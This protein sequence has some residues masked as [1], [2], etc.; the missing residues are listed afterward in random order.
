MAIADRCDECDD[1]LHYPSLHA[2]APEG[3]TEKRDTL[4][5]VVTQERRGPS[6]AF[7]NLIKQL[8][9]LRAELRQTEKAL[10]QARADRDAIQATLGDVLQG[11]NDG[12][13]RN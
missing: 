3:L 10:M 8:R 4:V 13:G 1:L 12:D 9:D 6:V 7:S 11:M 5:T 2:R